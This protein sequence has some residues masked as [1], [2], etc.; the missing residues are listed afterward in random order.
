MTERPE[1]W[2]AEPGGPDTLRF[3]REPDATNAF[4]AGHVRLMR[5]SLRRLAGAELC[6]PA[7]EDAEAARAVFLAPFAVVS[8]GTEADPVFNYGN[9]VALDLF[10]MTWEEFTALPSRLSAEAPEREE[11]MRLLAEVSAH[12]FIRDYAGIRISRSGKRFRIER[13][14]VWNLADDEGTGRGQAAMFGRWEYL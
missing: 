5:E 13:A 4:H 2:R 10:E 12:G 9:R 11:R 8:H 3:E 1:N 7:L 14:T 6:D